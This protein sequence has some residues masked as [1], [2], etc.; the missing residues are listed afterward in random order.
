M[1]TSNIS[2]D[3]LNF[4][5]TNT[6]KFSLKRLLTL[7]LKIILFFLITCF[8]SDTAHAQWDTVA[9]QW[10]VVPDLPGIRTFQDGILV[11]SNYGTFRRSDDYGNSWD[12]I[13]T[14]ATHID[15]NDN[16]WEESV[17]P[18][19]VYQDELRALVD[20]SH[21][22]NEQAD[23]CYKLIKANN[24]FT[25]FYTIDYWDNT[26]YPPN[27]E[28]ID[29]DGF[30]SL[31]AREYYVFGASYAAYDFYAEDIIGPNDNM[32]FYYENECVV[33]NRIFNSFAYLNGDFYRRNDSTLLKIHECEY[34]SD[35]VPSPKFNHYSKVFYG[36]EKIFIF[37]AP[38]TLY[39]TENGGESWDT[40]ILPFDS[41]STIF[42]ASGRFYLKTVH[43]IFTTDDI[44]TNCFQLINE[45]YVTQP[46]AIYDF[47]VYNG[48]YIASSGTEEIIAAMP[49]FVQDEYVT[50]S[51]WFCQGGE[52]EYEGTIYTNS[53][54]HTLHY[55]DDFGCD[56][57][58][59]LSLSTWQQYL[60][61]QQIEIPYG[62]EY[63]GIP[64]YTDTVFTDSLTTIHGCDS[65]I[66]THLSV[67]TGIF[68]TSLIGD[69]TIYPNPTSDILNVE[70]DLGYP[71][72]IDIE[73]YDILGN[74]VEIIKDKSISTGKHHLTIKT[75]KW[76][77]GI[78]F[79]SIK[80]GKGEMIKRIVKI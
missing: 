31:N 22:V 10:E 47:R 55:E 9:L 13:Y 73:I 51:D 4:H 77:K 33:P 17:G 35:T 25:S 39:S 40:Q 57:V 80:T 15:E 45:D 68:S 76:K 8:T 74:R 27:G 43:K 54:I 56:S 29:I 46:F 38:D 71:S 67:I 60:D 79:L 62:T 34:H 3:C 6:G 30:M 78:Y 36:D 14:P 19:F 50:I 23:Q 52:Y 69:L 66:E 49:N 5:K 37:L 12:T 16:W 61:E 2:Y 42:Y 18:I 64:I 72:A 63:N 21:E 75:E 65:V 32:D 59:Y 7:N 11:T 48:G 58:V 28:S 44:T 70:F 41:L 26:Y 1:K 20:C 53:G 24:S